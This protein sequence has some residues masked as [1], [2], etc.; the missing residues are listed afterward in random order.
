MRRLSCQVLAVA[1]AASVVPGVAS[2]ALFLTLSRVRAAPGEQVTAYEPV[3]AWTSA[4]G[5]DV[6]LVPVRLKALRSGGVLHAVPAGPRVVRLGPLT[7]DRR[8]RFAITFR[9][10]NVPAGDYTTAFW[11]PP[12]GGTFFTSA[13]PNDTWDPSGGPVLRVVR[14]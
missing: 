7:I 14:R 6:Y 8:H 5:I 10:P 1:A 3:A 4:T 9:V 11:C 2:A 13:A 12:C